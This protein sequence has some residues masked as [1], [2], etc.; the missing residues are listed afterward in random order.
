MSWTKSKNEKPKKSTWSKELERI[1]KLAPPPPKE[2]IY[3]YLKAV[4]RCAT[5]LGLIAEFKKK[6]FKIAHPKI[7]FNRFRMIIEQTALPYMKSK[8]KWKYAQALQYARHRQVK[9]SKVVGFIK[10]EGG[11]NK[12][13]DKYKPSKKP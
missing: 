8:M 3:P 5:R 7:K 12:C 2:A 9:R 6:E 10:S 4:Y 1:R 11:I 13:V